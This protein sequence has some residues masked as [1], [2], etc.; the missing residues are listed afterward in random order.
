LKNSIDIVY[1]EFGAIGGQRYLITYL[2]D[3]VNKEVL[4]RDIIGA[5]TSCTQT[6][7]DGLNSTSVYYLKATLHIANIFESTDLNTAVEKILAGDVIL[8]AEGLNVV[9]CLPSQGWDKRNIKEP[10]A[11]VITR[12]P[13]EGFV[14]TLQTNRSMIRRKLQNTD[15]CF[16]PLKLGEQTK[17][18]IN[19]VYLDN[20]VNTQ[21]LAELKKRLSKIDID[22]ILDA[23]Y[24]L[25]LIRDNPL[26]PFQTIG[27]SERP[28]VIVAK[29]LEGRIAILCDGTPVAITVP[30]LFLE[31]MQSNED[32]YT[33]FFA[34]SINRIVRYLSFVLTIFVPGLY[35]A[36]VTNHH[37]I[38]PSKL[39]F[40]LIAARAGVPFPTIIEIL[41]M[42]LTFEILRESG[43]RLPKGLGQTVSI[44]GALVLGQA[45]VEARLISA[46]VVIVIAITA[47]T[48]FMFYHMNGAIMI[49]RLYIILLSGLFGLY[50]LTLGLISVTIHMFSLH[51]FG[52]PYLS[53]IASLKEQ[54][55]KDTVIRAPWWYMHLRPKVISRRNNIREGRVKSK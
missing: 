24:I 46:P 19:L 15:L 1:Y 9:L 42:V 29:I 2:N 14:E 28:D 35:V 22:S 12:G 4:G 5:L 54:E 20:L 51:S 30:Y 21:I 34:S 25:E 27:C 10:D 11:E 31:S 33:G 37:E 16:E 45:A 44:V 17:T 13:K 43:L 52:I 32:Y 50:G 7:I 49:S 39:L 55:A 47:I 38:I 36:L 26:S 23:E 18:E 8:F 6:Q 3:L 40:S 48:S 41:A 53:Y